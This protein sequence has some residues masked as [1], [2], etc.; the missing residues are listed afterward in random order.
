MPAARPR[1]VDFDFIDPKE[2]NR[3]QHLP[4]YFFNWERLSPLIGYRCS[5]H[6][7]VYQL[8]GKLRRQ[9]SERELETARVEAGYGDD[10][11]MSDMRDV[12]LGG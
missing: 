4:E 7:T 12:R 3:D 11:D 1:L 9:M 8:Y 6:N 10:V 2:V 5:T